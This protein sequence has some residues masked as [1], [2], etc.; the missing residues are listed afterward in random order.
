MRT[1]D[2][3][4]SAHQ[5]STPSTAAGADSAGPAAPAR[6]EGPPSANQDGGPSKPE[7]KPW[8]GRILYFVGLI[9]M[10]LS[11]RH[12]VTGISPILNR[13]Q[14]DV[15]LGAAGATVLGMLPTIAFGVAGFVAPIFIRRLGPARMA[16]VAMA[17][18]ALGTVL[19]V[20]GDSTAGFLVFG[21]IALF[22]M[23]IGNV[24]GPPLVKRYFPDR[25]GAAMT[26]LTLMTQ[27][28]A[29]VPAM[30][31]VPMSNAA[32]WRVSIASYAVL[33][34]LAALPWIAASIRSGKEGSAAAANAG[35]N[36]PAAQKAGLRK[37]F[38]N[39]ISLGG[40]I[41]YGMAA[42]NTYAMLA[43]LPTIFQAQGLS[44]AEAA[45]MYSIYTFLTLPM[46]LITPIVATRMKNPFWL[47]LL[48][49]AA[50]IIGYLGIM[51]APGAAAVWAFVAGISGGAF[52]FAMVMFNLR[53]RTPEGSSTV[54]GFGLG[55]G[56]AFGTVGP[57]LGGLLSAL[58]GGWTV[59]LL[60]LIAA[61]VVMAVA[62]RMLTGN[63][64]FEDA[65]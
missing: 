21:A 47:G 24:V 58:S 22:G 31:A 25:Q 26:V 18:G 16:V 12:A 44:E 42:L 64:I 54:T 32:G 40:A 61:A 50:S 27:A 5:P 63:R 55:I 6:T 52:P 62:A 41:F 9:I 60:F 65:A 8:R 10:A 37:L 17:L 39:P 13:V 49:P 57:L 48:F 2:Q 30:L 43:W 1:K 23:G 35:G 7:P 11:L 20:L 45:G 36:Q 51:T 15:A 33:M 59:P 14:E 34:V 53:T 28:G 38:T 3:E 4:A 46:A 19:R 29:T 56:Y